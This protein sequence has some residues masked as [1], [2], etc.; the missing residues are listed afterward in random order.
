M[1]QELVLGTAA[2]PA[3]WAG[4]HIMPWRVQGAAYVLESTS[5]GFTLTCML[6][7]HAIERVPW[8]VNHGGTIAVPTPLSSAQFNHFLYNRMQRNAKCYLVGR[9]L[10]DHYGLLSTR[11]A[12]HL[13][14]INVSI[15]QLQG[16]RAVDLVLSLRQPLLTLS[17]LIRLCKRSAGAG[18]KL[19]QQ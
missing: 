9:T 17:I 18:S 15:Q 7:K 13:Q 2:L 3:R 4:L 16:R 1:L 5:N 12:V 10:I 11:S 14:F 6:Q 19:Q 8:S